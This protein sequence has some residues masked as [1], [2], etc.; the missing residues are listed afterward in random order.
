[1]SPEDAWY[2]GLGT[3]LA[4]RGVIPQEVD[5]AVT[6]ARAEAAVLTRW[7]ELAELFDALPQLPRF[8]AV[9]EKT[10][11]DLV[12]GP[13]DRPLV[14]HRDLHY[15]QL[16]WDGSTL[17]VLDVDTAARG[18]VALDLGNLLAHADLRLTQNIFTPSTSDTIA[19]HVNTVAAALNVNPARLETY[20]R[21]ALLRLACVYAFRPTSKDWL[22][23][24]VDTCV[25]LCP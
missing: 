22:P 2:R 15:K 19:G 12:A 8:R 4:S 3:E 18:E 14:L 7:L 16:L 13:A 1:M 21:A 9:V 10:A 11:H 20:H 5:R 6:D 17:G 25:T 23:G 24:W